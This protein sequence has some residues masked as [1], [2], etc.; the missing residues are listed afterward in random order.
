M[1]DYDC[2]EVCGCNLEWINLVSIC[3]TCEE[4]STEDEFNLEQIN[5]RAV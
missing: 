4:L 2:C 5:E 3:R 1:E